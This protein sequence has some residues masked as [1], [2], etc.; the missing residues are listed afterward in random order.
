M[1]GAIVISS[2]VILVAYVGGKVLFAERL[3]DLQ[4]GKDASFFYRFT[5][6]MLVALD[7]P[8]DLKAIVG[9]GFAQEGG[10]SC[11]QCRLGWPV[12]FSVYVVSII[13]VSLAQEPTP[14]RPKF[15]P[16]AQQDLHV[17]AIRPFT[18]KRCRG[19]TAQAMRYLHRAVNAE[20]LAP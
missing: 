12:D 10:V 19:R 8:A 20:D 16:F 9:V 7:M 3:H 1:A 15:N 18:L 11:V 4:S 17:L 13:A 5:G 2:L 14:A 6:P